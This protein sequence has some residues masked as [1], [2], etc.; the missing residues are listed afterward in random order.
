MWVTQEIQ[1]RLSRGFGKEEAQPSPGCRLQGPIPRPLT[2]AG[3]SQPKAF[4]ISP[5]S[6]GSDPSEES[7]VGHAPVSGLALGKE[8]LDSSPLGVRMWKGAG[9]KRHPGAL[10]GRKTKRSRQRKITHARS[11][12]E[13]PFS[14]RVR[15]TRRNSPGWRAQRSFPD[16]TPESANQAGPPRALTTHSPMH[17]PPLSLPPHCLLLRVYCHLTA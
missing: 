3:T 10:A 16:A 9:A 11:T 14:C 8:R 2:H 5:C 1:G 15:V 12:L 6:Q 17:R 4:S 13:P 7:Q